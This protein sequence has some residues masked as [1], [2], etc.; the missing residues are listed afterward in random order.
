VRT[1]QAILSML[2]V[3]ALAACAHSA[4]LP[5]KAIELNRDGAAAMA[6][7]DLEKA[8]ARI[9]LALEY[10]P[11]FTEAW[12]NLGLIEMS[13]G[14]FERGH[15]DFI[16]AR[17]LNPDLPAP[18]HSLGL[19]AD[20]EGHVADAE[21]YY[22][23]ALKVD[24]GFAP[25]RINLARRLFGRGS[26]E[27]AREQFLRV[28]QVAPDFVEGWA[29]LC[30]SLLRLQRAG[31]AEEVLARARERFGAHPSV[32]LLEARF[33]L[34][35]NAFAEAEKR[36]VPLSRLP[37]P[38]QASAALSW[39][40]IARLGEGDVASAIGA[41]ERAISLDPDDG[42]ARYAWQAVRGATR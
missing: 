34:R 8:E 16:K 20:H 27:E 3:P 18:H 28:T 36:L 24:P 35:R 17:D 25:A 26:L 38:R 10:N 7:G 29:G 32:E 11:H 21:R 19:L 2:L 42:V 41:A 4:P 14:N 31:E 13:R 15:R 12:V 9:A 40:A 30:E 5:A 23:A 39:L 6:A 33:L 1:S 22:R 37:D